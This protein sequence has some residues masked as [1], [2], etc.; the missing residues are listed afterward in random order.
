VNQSPSI[1]AP[2]G[3][4]A[5]QIASLGWLLTIIAAAVV[6][7]IGG[8]LIAALVRPRPERSDAVMR[9]AEPAASTRWIVIGGLV[10]PAVILLGAFIATVLTGRAVAAP[11]TRPVATIEVT[12]HRW[13][14]EIRYRGATADQTVLTANEIHVPVGGAVRIEL[15]SA[16]VI[17]SFWVPR[18]AAKTDLIPGQTNTMWIEARTAGV[19]RGECAEYCGLQHAQMDFVVVAE[20]PA[21]FAA[22]LAHQREPAVAPTDSLALDGRAGFAGHQCAACHAIEGTAS[23]GRIGP[24]LTHLASRRMIGAGLLENT[25][26]NLERWV[27]DAPSFKPG[28][29]MPAEPIPPASRAAVIAYLETL[30]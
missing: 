5:G 25:P 13:W 7:I 3:V 27:V 11:P 6:V 26:A 1:F 17:H 9:G 16:D 8:L 12:A 23:L 10:V 24:D 2:A 30:R 4:G 18:L 29:A 14:W 21:A 15:A 28:I 20:S 22:W 19:Y